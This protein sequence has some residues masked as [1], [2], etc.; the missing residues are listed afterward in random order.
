MYIKI[1]YINN[2]YSIKVKSFKLITDVVLLDPRQPELSWSLRIVVM[3]KV[4]GFNK[5]QYVAKFFGVKKLYPL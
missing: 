4:R 5:F 3:I 2:I 1:L